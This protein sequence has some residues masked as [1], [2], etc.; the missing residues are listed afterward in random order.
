MLRFFRQIRQKLITE[1]RFSKYLLYGIGEILL[2]VIGILIALQ[3][4]NWNNEIQ[5]RE[6]EKYYLKSVRTSIELSQNELDRVIRDAKLISSS[7]DTLFLLLAREKYGLLNGI[8]LDSLLF[9][10][11]DY[12][13]ISLNDGGIQEILNTG[14][15]GIITNDTIRVI[16]ASWNE[17]MHVIRKFEAETKELNQKYVA[18]LNN[19][20]NASRFLLDSVSVVIPEKKKTLLTDPLLRN[21]L[22]RITGLHYDMHDMYSEEKR[23]LDSLSGLIKQHLRE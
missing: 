5:D 7:A 11:A 20:I 8:F 1:N 17:R 6:K 22:E 15:L 16:L 23:M 13:Q 2:V 19:Y 12:S 10:A 3:I 18:Y 9:R 21:Y 14:S 4:N